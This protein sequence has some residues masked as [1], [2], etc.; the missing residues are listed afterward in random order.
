MA[1]LRHAPAPFTAPV[2]GDIDQRLA[3]IADALN[4]KASAT[5]PPAWPFIGLR[6]PNGTMFKVSVNDAGVITTEAV[7]RP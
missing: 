5:T 7:P 6:S 1:I 3:A 2:S 4:S